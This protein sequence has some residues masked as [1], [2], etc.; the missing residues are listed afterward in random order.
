MG[1]MNSSDM[2]KIIQFLPISLAGCIV[3]MLGIVCGLL[4]GNSQT[5]ENQ[6]VS[7]QA[8]NFSP[9]VVA[10][11]SSTDTK[12]KNTPRLGRAK[13]LVNI[14]NPSGLRKVSL[15][16]G[17]KGR[18]ISVSTG[19]SGRCMVGD[20]DIISK[21]LDYSRNRRLILSIEPLFKGKASFSPR[22]KRITE[23]QIA[24]GQSFTFTF[25]YSEEPW[26][27]AIYLCKDSSVEGLCSGKEIHDVNGVYNHYRKILTKGILGPMEEP[28]D[29]IYFFQYVLIQGDT[30]TAFDNQSLVE[31][32]RAFEHQ[33][34][35]ILSSAVQANS[36]AKRVYSLTNRIR[37]ASISTADNSS[38]LRLDLPHLERGACQE[39]LARS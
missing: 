16:N 21:E 8:K 19:S 9:N 15:V 33:L 30:I 4:F 7:P 25:P 2:T 3:L 6:N 13:K 11:L 14:S 5:S 12:K 22:A 36:V 28:S 23:A 18:V 38:R 17:K 35:P 1:V 39:G 37:S 20:L 31:N 29:K 26:H 32:N 27:A 10:N 24:R 34:R